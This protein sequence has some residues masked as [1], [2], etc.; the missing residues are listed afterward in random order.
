[1]IGAGEI[2]RSR[3]IPGLQAID[4]VEIVAVANR[5]RAS[6][7]RVAAQ[8]NIPAV[9]DHWGALLEDESIDAVC[10]GT[11][12]YLH[13]PITLAALARGKH[14]L[15]EA[16]LAMDLAEAKE[17]LAAARAHPELVAQVV[18]GPFTFHIDETIRLHVADGYLG[19]LLAV[20]MR[21]AAASF[22]DRDAPIIFRDER[23]YS[24]VNTMMIGIWYESLLRWTPAVS[25]VMAQSRVI[26]PMRR[27]AATGERRVAD[28]P[29]HVEVIGEMDGGAS[30]HMQASTVTGLNSPSE[31]WLFGTEGTLCYQ[32]RTR[33]LLGGRHG[34]SELTEIE[35]PPERQSR[36]RVEEEFI[37]AIRG[38]EPVRYTTFA[39]GVRYMAFTE[40]VARSAA[41][42]CI[43]AVEYP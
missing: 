43:V 10:I 1:M 41:E 7:E 2:A 33:R 21:L 14:V 12:P 37:G 27:D 11:W 30:F 16:R 31:V 5:S 26:V 4:G 19:D 36:W 18:P 25:R 23:Q 15:V 32:V 39:D 35:I 40:A 24:G 6:G 42:G 38:Q 34:D 8:F 29:D 3:H 20:D 17:M 13:C 22:V 9:Y 28:V